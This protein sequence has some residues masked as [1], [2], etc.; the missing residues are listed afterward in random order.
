VAFE[1]AGQ[2]FERLWRIRAG[3]AP[4]LAFYSMQNGDVVWQDGGL[5]TSRL[6]AATI[7]ARVRPSVLSVAGWIDV[8]G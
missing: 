5:N 6:L 8:V 2:T 7:I 3:L 4:L 1:P